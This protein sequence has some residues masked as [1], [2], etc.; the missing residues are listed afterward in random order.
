MTFRDEKSISNY[1]VALMTARGDL[2]CM[3]LQALQFYLR[4]LMQR[5]GGQE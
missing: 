1:F 4:A 5:V 3:E 2:F